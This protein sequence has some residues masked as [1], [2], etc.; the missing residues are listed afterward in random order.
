MIPLPLSHS[1]ARGAFC[2]SADDSIAYRY[3]VK[4]PVLLDLRPADCVT[5]SASNTGRFAMSAKNGKPCKKCGSSDW[6]NHGHCRP[7]Q[8]EN[9]RRRYR[10]NPEKIKA[11][12]Y[13]WRKQNPEK[14]YETNRAYRLRTPDKQRQYH[15][16]Y[17]QNNIE[18]L[19]TKARQWRERN[20][21]K[22]REIAR[23]SRKNNLEVDREK[24][25][26][27]RAR[28]AGS[29]GKYSVAEWR[30]LVAHYGNKC[31][32]CGRDDVLLTVDHVIPLV[33]GG[34]N[35]IDNLQ[36]LCGSCNSRKSDKSIDY[37]PSAGLGRW[38]Q[39]KL[40]E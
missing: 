6:D 26:R 25:H 30:S 16:T 14:V 23:K 29:G 33:R 7:C 13:Q 37:R 39:R 24:S 9:A 12:V 36:P 28:K 27:Y 19:A 4:H 2:S 11:Q 31:L 10:E 18:I 1:Q 22:F 20:R 34:T 38:I 21:D 35:T 40:I 8:R 5:T 3:W 15:R 17:T 32:C